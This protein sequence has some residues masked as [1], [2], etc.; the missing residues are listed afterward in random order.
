MPDHF[1]PLQSLV[2]VVYAFLA[3]FGWNFGSWVANKILAP[4]RAVARWNWSCGADGNQGHLPIHDER[5]RKCL[6]NQ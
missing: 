5:K 1:I 6:T 3:G 4:Y 2:V